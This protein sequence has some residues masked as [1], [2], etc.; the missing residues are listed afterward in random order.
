[1]IEAPY[2]P[3]ISASSTKETLQHSMVT[4]F[5]DAA[6]QDVHVQDLNNSEETSL[7][8]ESAESKQTEL[9]KINLI[10]DLVVP[11][12]TLKMPIYTITKHIWRN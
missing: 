11:N 8:T 6:S 7:C 10:Y 5:N 12:N 1:M 3:P 2:I 9:W 4:L